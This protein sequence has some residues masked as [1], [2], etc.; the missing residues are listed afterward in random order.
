[1]KIP[2]P[3]C[4]NLYKLSKK[5]LLI[6]LFSFSIML[7][8]GQYLHHDITGSY[9]FVTTDQVADVLKDVL[10]TVFSFGTYEKENYDYSGALFLTY[11]RPVTYRLHMGGTV[12]IDNVSGD[13][14]SNG[15]AYGTFHTRHTT[16]A[17][18]ADLRW[19]KRNRLQ[20]YSGLGLG[21]TFTAEEGFVSGS[22]ESDINRSGHLAIQVT[23]IGLRIGR[24][25]GGFMEAGFGYKGLL[26]FGLSYQFE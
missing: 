10:T 4:T 5:Y 26:N 19:V 21:Y 15:T 6:L 18:E 17:G 3:P 23:A 8:R 9:G 25:F 7:A 11:K 12:G 1:M 24:K 13:L 2:V 16:F 20:M 14:L 22:G